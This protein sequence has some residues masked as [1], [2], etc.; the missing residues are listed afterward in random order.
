MYWFHIDNICLNFCF[1][2]LGVINCP[3]EIDCFDFLLKKKVDIVKTFRGRNS[4]PKVTIL[5]CVFKHIQ[6][7]SYAEDISKCILKK[8]LKI[9]QYDY[10]MFFQWKLLT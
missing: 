6:L 9:K 5:K 8:I 1:I 2:L 10:W 7:D 4:G 3:A